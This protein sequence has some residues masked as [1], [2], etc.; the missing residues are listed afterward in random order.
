MLGICIFTYKGILINAVRLIPG[1]QA[2]K[3]IARRRLFSHALVSMKR[4][5]VLE[6]FLE[7]KRSHD[8]TPSKPNLELKA[9]FVDWS[10][11]RN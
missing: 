2:L 10:S 8:K 4:I 5:T 9:A 7:V 11:Y 6:T 3:E 1:H